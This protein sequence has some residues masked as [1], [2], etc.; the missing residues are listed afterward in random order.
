MS[1]SGGGGPGKSAGQGEE[2]TIKQIA[3]FKIPR[4][5]I[6]RGVLMII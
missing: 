4:G 6:C 3:L 1:P 5:N 2:K